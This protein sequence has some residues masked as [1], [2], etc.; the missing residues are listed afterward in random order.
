MPNNYLFLFSTFIKII[1]QQ[2]DNKELLRVDLSLFNYPEGFEKS[3]DTF[4]CDVKVQFAKANIIFLFKHIDA[5]LGF[6]DSLNII[7]AAL[8]IASTQADA[9]F[10]QEQAFKVHL[11]IAFNAQKI[12]ISTNSYSDQAHFLDLGKL[13]LKTTFHD[14]PKRCLV[15][16]QNVRLKNILASRVKFDRDCNIIGEATL[17]EC[18]ELNTLINRLLYPEKVKAEPAVSIK[19]DWKLVHFRLAKDGYSCVMRILMENF[20]ENIRYQIPEESHTDEILPTLRLRAEIKK[21][22]L[23]LYFGGS[24][25]SVRRE[26]RNANL[27]L[28]NV[29]IE[30]LKALFRQN[31]DGSYKATAN[32]KNFLLDDLRETNKSTS[33]TRMM[34]RHFTV[35]PN[36]H[37]FVASFDFKPKNQSRPTAFRQLT[38]Q[39]ES[40]YICISLDYLMTLQDFFISG[41]PSANVE[42]QQKA[43]QPSITTTDQ[44]ENDQNR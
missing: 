11:D 20:S 17:L 27:K 35:D 29:Q 23:K 36:T 37:M 43:E 13:I 34:N 7:K 16:R 32:V 38:A 40:L 21:L 15:E 3:I 25:L 2:G 24:D 28:A 33:V 22:V 14:D 30:I 8:I 31:S 19:V 10:E 41:L 44:S 42:T 9:A 26:P 5:I 6:L 4:D 12:I 18:A 1:S 39:L